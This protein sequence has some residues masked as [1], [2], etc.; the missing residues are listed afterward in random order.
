MLH[1]E[2]VGW[3]R[4]FRPESSWDYLAATILGHIQRQR[5]GLN[6]TNSTPAGGV[7]FEIKDHFR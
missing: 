2:A 3:R 7:T 4:L 6:Q 1:Y 5:A